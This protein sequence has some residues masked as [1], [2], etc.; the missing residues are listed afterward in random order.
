MA[1]IASRIA[2]TST[3]LLLA[4]MVGGQ[5]STSIPASRPGAASQPSGVSAQKQAEQWWLQQYDANRNGTLDGDEKA[6]WEQAVAKLKEQLQ[7]NQNE[8]LMSWDKDG[9]G[10]FSAEEAKA[11]QAESAMLQAEWIARWDSNGDG[12]LD[13]DE[14]RAVS[15]V[16]LTELA[17]RRLAMDTDGDGQVKAQEAQA[18]WQKVRA[19]YDLDKDGTLNNQERAQMRKGEAL[20]GQS[21]IV[22]GAWAEGVTPPPASAPTTEPAQQQIR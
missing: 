9:N 2:L 3:I 17:Q 18:Y 1:G 20:V 10:Q 11:M 6:K 15:W 22:S 21:W 8:W 13:D 14:Q 5:S 7:K 16:G 19:K 4:H 12:K